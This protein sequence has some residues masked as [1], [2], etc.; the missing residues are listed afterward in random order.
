ME[1]RELVAAIREL[2]AR[3][4]G[5]V[6]DRGLSTVRHLVDVA[7]IHE[8]MD[9]LVATLVRNNVPITAAERDT[10]ASLMNGLDLSED[11]RTLYSYLGDPEMLDRMTVVDEPSS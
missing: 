1:Y 7:E 2:A 3:V 9:V 10:V 6:T 5:R 4:S 11:D 8:A